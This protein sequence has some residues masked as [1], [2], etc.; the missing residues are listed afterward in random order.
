MSNTISE[1]QKT[2]EEYLVRNR[3]ILDVITKLE[4]TN[5]R[6]N[7]ALA[8]SI[9]HCGCISIDAKKPDIPSDVS[10]NTLKDY[11]KSNIQGELCE[12]CKEVIESE[13]GS[14]LFY[15]AALCNQ[16]NLDMETVLANEKERVTVLGMFNLS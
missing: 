15:L 4:Q 12:D 13:L 11:I 7:R 2:V 8:K 6:I 5:A 9:T 1:F 10:Y 16:L 3:S 14:H